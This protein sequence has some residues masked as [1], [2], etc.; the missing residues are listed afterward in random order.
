[1]TE[2][3]VMGG[4]DLDGMRGAESYKLSLTREKRQK[5]AWS[6]DQA[7]VIIST[8]L[9]WFFVLYL[10][11]SVPSQTARKSSNA[12]VNYTTNVKLLQRTKFRRERQAKDRET[13]LCCNR[14]LWPS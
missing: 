6:T 5:M 13:H 7:F 8:V 10:V 4:R 14:Y 11:S 9:V 3:N 12:Y 2:Q 1:M